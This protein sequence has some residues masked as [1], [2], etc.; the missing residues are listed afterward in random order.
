MLVFRVVVGVGDRQRVC[1]AD[2]ALDLVANFDGVVL[3][4]RADSPGPEEPSPPRYP[5]LAQGPV[6]D[7]GVP[8]VERDELCRPT[9]QRLP[10]C[11]G[12]VAVWRRRR[13]GQLHR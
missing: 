4:V 12:D 10:L 7:E 13:A 5:V 3:A 1:H 2:L 9:R 6:E 8:T 11:S